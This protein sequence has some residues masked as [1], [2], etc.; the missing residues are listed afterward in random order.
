MQDLD[1][2]PFIQVAWYKFSY[3]LMHISYCRHILPNQWHRPYKYDKQMFYLFFRWSSPQNVKSW[4]THYV[5]V[6]NWSWQGIAVYLNTWCCFSYGK[7]FSGWVVLPNKI[8][9]PLEENTFKQYTFKVTIKSKW[10]IVLFP[11]L[12]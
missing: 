7:D 5:M 10:T 9:Q 1:K 3:S 11:P 6:F 4:E 8:K 2:A 12:L